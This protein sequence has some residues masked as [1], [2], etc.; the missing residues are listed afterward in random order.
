MHDFFHLQL[1]IRVLH[2]RAKGISLSV[3]CAVKQQGRKG[4]KIAI[5]W[6]QNPQFEKLS[7]P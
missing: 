5:S 7:Q 3:L 6:E 1:M 4:S 2:S